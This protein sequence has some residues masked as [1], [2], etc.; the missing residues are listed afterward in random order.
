MKNVAVI[1]AAGQGKRMNSEVKK[2]F[3]IIEG[4]SVLT[5]SLEMFEKATF[6]T[7]IVIVTSEDEL[8][9]I[10]TEYIQTRKLIKPCK[11]IVGGKERYHSVYHAL[12]EIEVCDYVFIH[13]A[14]RP[15]LTEDILNRTYTCV[16]EYKA[17]VTG[18]LSKD[19]VKISSE[20]GYV[21]FTP[22]RKKV[23]IIQTPQVFEFELIHK[24]YEELILREEELV[25]NGIQI[26]DDAMVAETFSRVRVK[27]V[28]GDYHNIKITTPEDIQIASAFIKKR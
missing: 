5:Y 7:E 19:T 9:Y 26:T 22:N 16:K 14:A 21:E 11:V 28:E 10:Q 8:E 4:K 13:D 15:F 3:L 27:L 2:Q 25:E 6:I 17:C 24:A 1:L 23:W 18:V 12:K 20:D